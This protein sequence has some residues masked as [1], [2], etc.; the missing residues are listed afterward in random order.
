MVE[1]ALEH[2]RTALKQI[3]SVAKVKI[4]YSNGR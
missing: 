1:T 2:F 3:K 4:P